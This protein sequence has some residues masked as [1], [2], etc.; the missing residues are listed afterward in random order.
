MLGG[1]TA[2]FENIFVDIDIYLHNMETR[3]VIELFE[4]PV[5][6]YLR[7]QWY[8][9]PLKDHIKIQL[10]HKPSIVCLPFGTR[11]FELNIEIP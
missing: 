11:I 6:P 4:T 7:R 2:V 10:P 8:L 3:T 5:P 9:S 1:A